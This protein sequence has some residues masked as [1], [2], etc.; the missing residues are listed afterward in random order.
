LPGAYKSSQAGDVTPITRR[1]EGVGH[2]GVLAVSAGGAGE[3]RAGG[4]GSGGGAEKVVESCGGGG[5][6]EGGVRDGIERC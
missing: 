5:G 2:D 4:Q 6:S 3:E 1:G